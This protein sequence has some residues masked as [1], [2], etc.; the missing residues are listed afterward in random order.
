MRHLLKDVFSIIDARRV[1]SVNYSAHRKSIVAVMDVFKNSQTPLN[2]AEARVFILKGV[3]ALNVNNFVR[4][5]YLFGDPT[6][7]V[8]EYGA[9]FDSK[10]WYIKIRID[11][12]SDL[13]IISFHPP[14]KVLKTASGLLIPK[15]E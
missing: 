2:A 6:Y 13:E 10:P 14:E 9:I 8:D 7:V 15:G 5:L 12:D 11:D 4:T 1:N 3:R